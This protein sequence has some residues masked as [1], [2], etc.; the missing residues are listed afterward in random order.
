MAPLERTKLLAGFDDGSG[1]STF[2]RVMKFGFGYTI[3][4]A[5]AQSAIT[6]VHFGLSTLLRRIF[7]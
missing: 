2:R 4:T 7:G 1:K 5:V 3:A 6:L